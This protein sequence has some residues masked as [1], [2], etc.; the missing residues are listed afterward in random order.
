M[1]LFIASTA[2][3]VLAAAPQDRGR[4]PRQGEGIAPGTA[5]AN[6]DLKKLKSSPDEKDERVELASFKGRKPVVLIFGSYT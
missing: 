4:R 2:I 3:L 5:A 1:R 6:F